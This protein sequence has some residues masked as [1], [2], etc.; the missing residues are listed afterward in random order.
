MKTTELKVRT[1]TL[2]IT[3]AK[4]TTK[5]LKQM[6]IIEYRRL[7]DIQ[8]NAI[9]KKQPDPILG[10][11]DGSVLGDQYMPWFIVNAGEGSYVRY[12]GTPTMQSQYPQIFV[13]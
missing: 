1:A 6:Q 8:R 4:L 10:W 3:T 11:V 5:L 12:F 7:H 13:V 9:E 2:E